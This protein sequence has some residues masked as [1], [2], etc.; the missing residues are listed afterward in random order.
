MTNVKSP[1]RLLLLS[2][3]FVLEACGSDHKRVNATPVVLDAEVSPSSVTLTWADVGAASYNLY[4]S[5]APNCDLAN[6][7]VCPDGVMVADV[8]APHTVTALSNG[9]SY[10]FRVESVAGNGHAYSNEAGVRPDQLVTNGRVRAIATDSAGVAYLGGDFT[11]VGMVT[12]NGVTLSTATGQVGAFPMVNGTIYSAAADGAGGFYI[13]GS[14]TEVGG[15]VRNRLAHILADGTLGAWQPAA[16]STVRALAV[17]VSTVYVGGSFSTIDD[18]SGV[19]A[20]SQLAAIDTAGAL[21]DIW[22]P[23]AN[24]QVNALAVLNGTVYV[25]GSFTSIDDGAAFTRDRLAAIGPDGAVDPGWVP[26]A[27]N[28]VYALAIDGSTVYVGG[29]FSNIEEGGVVHARGRLAAIGVAG[30]VDQNWMPVANNA[31][32]ALAVLNGTVYAGGLFTNITDSRGT[33]TRNRLAAIAPN[34]NLDTG[35]EPSADN[36]VS[37]LAALGDTLYVGG[38][39]TTIS[40]GSGTHNRNCLAAIG[41]NGALRAWNPSPNNAVL[42]LAVS[43]GAV[44]AGGL[45]NFINSVERNHMAAMNADGTISSWNPDADNRVYALAMSGTTI[46]AGGQFTS[47]AGVQHNGLAAVD[48]DGTVSTTWSPDVN[49]WVY[50][51][52]VLNNVVYAGGSFT[53]IDT[54]TRNNL[55]AIDATGN[56]LPGWDPNAD[57]AVYAL[58]ASGTTIYAGGEFDNIGGN[59]RSHLAAIDVNNVLSTSWVPSANNLVVR[60]LAVS[61]NVVYAGGDFTFVN[62]VPRAHLAAIDANGLLLDTWNPG[63]NDNVYALA[64]SGNTIYAGGL[65]T[66]IG[67]QP[68]NHIAAIGFDGTPSAAWNPGANNFVEAL[69]T[70]GN[71]V[72]AGGAFTEADGKLQPHFSVLKP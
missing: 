34:G 29:L 61:G 30:S 11:R 52:A 56:L 59:G 12:G 27:D 49:G 31:V 15:Q 69:A 28:A 65:F 20:R 9:Q 4:Y 57:Q 24:G 43:D 68:Y 64:A 62:A 63:A 13:G 70:S 48:A 44:Y 21:S 47:V 35:W 42:A 3:V 14:F 19:Q 32:F 71:A 41:T 1:V 72:Y 53:L 46:Y 36:L 5:T 40:D 6:Y 51:L 39:Y 50:A 37:S 23:S 7:A 25:G 45:M 26:A 66:T 54:I 38:L 58:A 2:I 67:G 18:G 33:L 16:D 55:A 60:A 10:W 8:T 17:S 22:K